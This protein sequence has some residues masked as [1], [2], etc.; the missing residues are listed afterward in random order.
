MDAVEQ[1]YRRMVFNIVARNQDDHVKNIAFLMNRG[2]SWELAPAFDVT[3]AY[4]PSGRWTNMHQMSLNG[5]RD[6]FTIED[7]R[8]CAQAAS[9]KR[10]LVGTI[11]AEVLEATSNWPSYA[12]DASVDDDQIARIQRAHRLDFLPG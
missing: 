3:Y 1:Q 11:L 10:G 12:A 6:D 2:G 9:M 7:F 8:Q 5:K 4:Q